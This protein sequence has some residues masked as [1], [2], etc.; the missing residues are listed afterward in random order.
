MHRRRTRQGAAQPFVTPTDCLIWA[1]DAPPFEP[2][3]MNPN[4]GDALAAW[5]RLG[6]RTGHIMFS[7]SLSQ[8]CPITMLLWTVKW[9]L[10]AG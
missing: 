2:G 9:N 10:W 8:I 4:D 5:L 1:E 6:D 3:L 7:C